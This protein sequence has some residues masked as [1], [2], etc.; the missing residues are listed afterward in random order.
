MG[1]IGK[2][3]EVEIVQ[4]MQKSYLD[5]A[6]SVIVARALPD[7]RDGL[8]PV[9]RRIIYAMQ[10]LGVT[11]TAHY[12]KSA[13]VVG[14]V[15][16]KYH[17]HGDIPVYDAMVR[18]AQDFA[19]RYQLIDGQGNFGSVDG[20]SAAAMRYTEA[21]LSAISE[22]LLYDLDKNTV[23][24][25]DNFD[26]SLKEPVYLP[27][28]LPNLLINGGSGIAVGMAT[29]I[30]P[31]N[32]NEIIDATVH[33]I[34]NPDASVED[35]MQFV[36]GPDFPTGAQI[37]DISEIT[38]AYAT[39]RGKIIMRAKADIEETKSG[40]FQIG[41]S[42]IPYQVNKAT[43]VT[44][45]ADLVKDKKLDGIAD[46]RDES[47]RKGMR[48]VV[49]LKRDARP[50]AVL[51]NLFKHTALQQSF[52]VNM[53]ALVEGTPQ[54]LTLKMILEQFI[55]HRKNVITRRSQFELDEAKKREHILEGLKIAVD[56]IDE[57]IETIKKSKDQQDA[58]EN[59]M[60]RF[61][62]SEIQSQAILDM[63][64]KRLAALE[65]QKI[66][67]ELK[68]IREL[69]AYLEDLLAHPEKI[70]AVAK[71][72]LLKLKERFG[73]ERKTRVFKQ[74]IGEFSEEDLIPNEPTIVTITVGGYV[75]RQD[76]GSFR[77]QKRGGK[78]ISGITTKEED[79]VAQLFAAQT[80]DNLL[81]FTNRGRVFQL[82]VYELP[83]TSRI[84]KGSAIVN[85]LELGA[86]EKILSI[87][88][89][90]KQKEGPKA[91]FVMMATKQG[92]IKKTALV[93]YESI[94]RSGII[95]IKLNA[96]DQLRWAKLTTGT[97]NVMVISKKGMSLKFKETD[98]RPMARD[99]MGVR[100]IKIKTDDELIGMDIVDKEDTKADLLVVTERGIGKKTPVSAWP[101]QLRGGVGVKAAHLAEKTGNL[102]TAQVLN[103]DDEALIL[104]SQRGQ[105]LRTTLRSIPR[106]TRDTQGVIIM[107][108]TAADK[109]AAATIILKKKDENEE[110]EGLPEGI[111]QSPKKEKKAEKSEKPAKAKKLVAIKKKKG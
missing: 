84:A 74:K 38:A 57:V 69:I 70:L 37:Y 99:T 14:E 111:E 100:G 45:I 64:L 58:K 76:I 72:E 21:R 35:L 107:R 78:G 94:R 23:D 90:K 4:E 63:Q 40:K 8:K 60:T 75:K 2:I 11:H 80:H 82:K 68:M 88:P 62:L 86:E 19:M 59:L 33:M 26:G 22:G 93:Q 56:N 31:H 109:V 51:N 16:G 29:N 106:L 67:E 12:T 15:L 85:L 89:V 65:R 46:L 32:I 97:D 87:L 96:G 81:F 36:K 105:V 6:M 102:V 91:A 28:V 83:D 79:I 13:K 49:E 52:A 20:D 77:T 3:Q 110:L 101:L 44:R 24:W 54:T 41:I 5:Y 7:V 25:I 71:S 66:E 34:D 43:L 73:D 103:R 92:T 95:A 17:P 50:K 30:P 42:E 53:V 108:L 61:K 98:V 48:I 9:H 47:D 55:K 39:G 1:D 104:T 27:A 10:R 18:M